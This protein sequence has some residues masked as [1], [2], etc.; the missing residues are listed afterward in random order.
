MVVTLGP[1][2]M[3]ERL[4]VRD[5]AAVKGNLGASQIGL[6]HVHPM[7]SAQAAVPTELAHRAAVMTGGKRIVETSGQCA[8]AAPTTLVLDAP[9]RGSHYIAG[10]GCCYGP[11]HVRASLPLDGQLFTAQRFAID[12]EQ[13]VRGSAW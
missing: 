10:D 9:L 11:R 8:V 1:A 7:F 13:L 2:D 3:A 6:V 4:V 12:W 5:K